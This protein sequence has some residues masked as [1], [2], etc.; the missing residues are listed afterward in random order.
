VAFIICVRFSLWLVNYLETRRSLQWWFGKQSAQLQHLSNQVQEE[1]FQD[2][3]TIRRSLELSLINPT[4]ISLQARQHWLE[5][6]EKLYDSLEQLSNRLSPPYLEENLALAI[7]AIAEGWRSHNPHLTLQ[8]HL[9]TDWKWG[10][11]D[12]NRVIITTLS[13]LLTMTLSNAPPETELQLFL[14]ATENIGE[15]IVQISYPNT[16]VLISSLNSE[17]LTW[18]SRSFCFLTSGWCFQQRHHL[19]VRWHFRWHLR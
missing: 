1:L 18:L 16:S 13:E 17:E 10:S 4:E 9:S 3:F 2:I 8:T 5:K 12:H 11:Y 7:Q 19:I 6:I 14:E 15:L